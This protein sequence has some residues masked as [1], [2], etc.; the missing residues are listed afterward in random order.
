MRVLTIVN[1]LG[2]GGIEKTFL[3]CVPYLMNKEIELYVCIFEKDGILEENFKKR[4]VKILKIKKT[5]SILIDFYQINSLIKKNNIDLIHSRFGFSSGGFVLASVFCKIPS[6]VS[7]HSTHH[8]KTPNI[9]TRIP[10]YVSLKLHKLITYN[11]ATKIIG[12]SKANLDLNFKNWNS[13]NKFNVIYNGINFLKLKRYKSKSYLNYRNQFK[14]KDVLLHIGSFR[15]Q[16][17]HE[18]MLKVFSKLEPSK[19]NLILILVGDGKKKK[20]LLDL[21]DKLKIRKNVIFAGIQKDI[22][23]YLDISK[24]FFFPSIQ[25]GF[26]NVI[27]EAQYMN[28]P[29]CG[30]NIP[31]LNESIY[32]DFHQYRFNPHNI[33][34]ATLK[35]KEIINDNNS[36]KL[37]KSKVKAANFV[38][39]NFAIEN[40]AN[41]LVEL[42]TEIESKKNLTQ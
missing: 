1:S 34:E 15:D 7:L 20:S 38:K 18:F 6:I 4:G 39:R 24:I 26:G 25:E 27:S 29:V 21:V 2:M 35:L 30:S 31:S 28:I 5:N 41:K 12:H 10:L 37:E 33:E 13:N 8:G 16:K 40:M 42:Y 9:L 14:D 19:N 36:G 23:K 32:E 17:N 22:G 11:F 3:L